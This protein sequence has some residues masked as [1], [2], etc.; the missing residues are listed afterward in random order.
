VCAKHS[1]E[2]AQQVGSTDFAYSIISS[3]RAKSEQGRKRSE[4]THEGLSLLW[5][6]AFRNRRLF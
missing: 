2:Q 6:F 3:A 1:P 5:L 4:F